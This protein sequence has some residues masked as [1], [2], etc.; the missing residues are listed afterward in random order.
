[1]IGITVN[2][3]RL[4]RPEGVTVEDLLRSLDLDPGRVAIELDG[5]IVRQPEWAHTVLRPGS[6]VEVVHFVGGG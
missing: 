2:G 3:E 4:E 6:Q 1:M 5:A